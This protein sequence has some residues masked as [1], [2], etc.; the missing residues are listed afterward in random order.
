MRRG[1]QATPVPYEPVVRV[2]ATI[3]SGAEISH[4]KLARGVERLYT[5]LMYVLTDKAG[6]IHFPKRARRATR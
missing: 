6:T 1:V 2:L 4:V 3:I 5:N